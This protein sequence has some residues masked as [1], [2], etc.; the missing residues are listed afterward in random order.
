[1]A[2]SSFL[3][4]VLPHLQLDGWE[5]FRLCDGPVGAFAY[6]AQKKNDEAKKKKIPNRKKKIK[7]QNK[8]SPS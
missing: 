1:L 8:K 3:P 7:M 5:T 2:S 4:V 6:R